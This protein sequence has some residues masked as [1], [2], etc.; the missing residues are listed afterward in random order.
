M[1]FKNKKLLILLLL[2]AS[3][4]FLSGCA[5]PTDEA[6][7]IIKI[8]TETTFKHIFETEGWFNTIFVYPLSQAI[9]YLAP[10]TGVALAITIVTVIV[11]A[12]ILLFTLK[13]TIQTQQMQMLQPELDKINKKYEGKTD[14]ASKMKQAQEMQALYKKY[15]INPFGAILTTFIQLPIIMA[16]YQSVQRSQAVYEGSFWGLSLAQAPLD[17]IKAGQ[18]LYILLFVVMLVT[19]IGS[20]MLPQYLNKKKII[21]EAELHHKKPEIPKNPN[22]N[23]MYYMMI[24][25]LWLSITWPA[26]MTVYWIINSL[27]MISKTLIVQN[28][29]SNHQKEGKY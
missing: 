23:M 28:I 3:A 18:F 6:G 8:T 1:K 24:P 14:E 19:Q 5:A 20:M 13:S 12:F 10:K 16:M 17:G 27:I 26:A 29:I 9:N 2:V 22:Q 11:N 7:K 15:N 21:K 25:I 4:L